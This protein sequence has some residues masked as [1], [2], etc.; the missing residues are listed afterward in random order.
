[1]KDKN[2]NNQINES[3]K[4]SVT[5]ICDPSDNGNDTPSGICNNIGVKDLFVSSVTVTLEAVL[6]SS[7]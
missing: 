5:T 1:M 3:S 4:N 6:L 7:M 2:I